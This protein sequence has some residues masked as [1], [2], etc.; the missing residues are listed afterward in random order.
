MS[1]INRVIT[2]SSQWDTD[3]CWIAKREIPFKK[4]DGLN[5]LTNDPLEC[6]VDRIWVSGGCI[7][8]SG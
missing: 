3:N 7:L 2:L 1:P 4:F 6:R 8:G 5:G